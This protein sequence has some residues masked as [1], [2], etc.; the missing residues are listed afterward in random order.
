MPEL[1]PLS[2][3]LQQ[4]RQR[5]P[6][7][8]ALLQRAPRERIPLGQ[9]L[10]Q[11]ADTE[12]AG[13]L[14]QFGRGLVAPV[15]ELGAFAGQAVR[16]PVQT[17]TGIGRSF[18]EGAKAIP[19]VAR[20]LVS[21]DPTVRQAT[22][23]GAR[24]GLQESV[25]DDDPDAPT[26]ERVGRITGSA[27]LGLAGAKTLGAVR[28]IGKTRPAATATAR[29]ALP[30]SSIERTALQEAAD[31]SAGLTAD[32]RRQ[33]ARQ[34]AGF[35]R[36]LPERA[37][38]LVQAE[39]LAAQEG[40]LSG[41]F[42]APVDAPKFVG[43]G[44]TF[45]VAESER[46]ARSGAPEGL[47]RPLP[48]GDEPVRGRALGE[49]PDL[50]Q[51]ELARGLQELGARPRIGAARPRG[52]PQGSRGGQTR[53]SQGGVAQGPR[54]GQT[55]QQRRL[56]DEQIAADSFSSFAQIGDA[57]RAIGAS[58]DE[59]AKMT[60][61]QLRERL[62]KAPHE[63]LI[64]DEAGRISIEKAIPIGAGLAGAAIGGALA[65]TPEGRIGAAIAFGLVGARGTQ[66]LARWAAAQ[67]SLAQAGFDALAVV[68]SELALTGTALPKNVMNAVGAS[69]D[70]AFLTGSTKPIREMFRLPTNLREFAAGTR[71]PIDIGVAGQELPSASSG[72]GRLRPTRL[73]SGVDN[74]VMRSL[75]RAGLTE[76][77]VDRLL[78]RR[79]ITEFL[80]PS[81]TKVLRT[82]LARQAVLFQRTPMNQFGS[83]IREIVNAGPRFGEP[84]RSAFDQRRARLTQ[85]STLGGAI[86]SEAVPKDEQGALLF[87]LLAASR[88]V[89]ALPF[90]IGGT[91]PAALGSRTS[92]GSEALRGTTP[93]PEFGLDFRQVLPQPAFPR[94][95]RV[96]R[97]EQ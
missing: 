7:D 63:R 54:G 33:A 66:A 12:E 86:A 46:R 40:P 60:P 87:A 56:Q 97:G 43:R 92:I 77:E 62:A 29:L 73:I 59:V 5:I 48:P 37:E 61:N 21:D 25:L 22:R 95:V 8:E 14:E 78:L 79:P 74:Q 6:L 88:G 83:G 13:T 32:A 68:R 35:P 27:L 75:R 39:R 50:A 16:H 31:R 42:S 44:K 96:L 89:N 1:L 30:P 71:N 90:A 65:E 51:A 11:D 76:A 80:S 10:E 4:Q 52:A 55:R 45:R 15:R 69:L 82:P 91:I 9:A 18:I 34:A 93:F 28:R 64:S 58:V 67:P 57:A 85:A 19:D 84:F 3:A 41:A 94:M 53:Q 26:A 23:T 2:L 17:V 81:F 47:S 38:S 70:A 36:L 24:L 20:N 72:L 49:H